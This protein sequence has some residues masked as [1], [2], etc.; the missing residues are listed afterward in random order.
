MCT[1]LVIPGSADMESAIA[2]SFETSG[3]RGWFHTDIDLWLWDGRARD[4]R[5]SRKLIERNRQEFQR[6]GELR[7]AVSRKAVECPGRPAL[8][9]ALIERRRAPSLQCFRSALPGNAPSSCSW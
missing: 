9:Y 5:Y 1:D 3:R 8:A 7:D 4:A 2:V 6:Y